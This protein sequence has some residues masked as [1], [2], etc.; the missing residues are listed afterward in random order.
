MI[1]VTKKDAKE[2]SESLLRRF[3]R[4]VQ[5]SGVLAEAKMNQRFEKPMSKRDR[6]SKAIIRK[7]RKNDK[8]KKMR[9]G[10]ATR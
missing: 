6:R 9:L 7:E 5:Q 3:N 10:G 1:Q 8:M 2:S 4:K